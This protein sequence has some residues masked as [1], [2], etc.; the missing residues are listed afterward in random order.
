VE[1]DRPDELEPRR[2]QGTR[3]ARARSTRFVVIAAAIV[4]ALVAIVAAAVGAFGSSKKV[5]PAAKPGA[6][7]AAVASRSAEVM[8]PPP[9]GSLY[10]GVYP[11]GTTGEEDDITAASTDEY[12]AAVGHKVA[13]VYFSNNWYKSAAFPASTCQ[14][15]AARGSVPYI[16]LMLRSNIEPGSQEPTFTLDRI[17]KGD[18]DPQ[19]KAWAAGAASFGQPVM[20]EYGPEVN[21]D[22][23]PWNGS[24]NG[25]GTTTGFGDPKKA[26]GPE[27]FAAAYRHIID[28]MRGQGAH[29]VS[30]VF[31]VD[32]YGSPEE[33]WNA[34]AA[35]YPGDDYIDWLALSA[36]GAQDS[37]DDVGQSFRELVDAGYPQLAK[38]S[39]TKPIIIAEMG[40]D[41]RN[42]VLDPAAW[43]KTALTDMLAGKRWP[44]IAGFS[45]WDERWANDEDPANDSDMRVQDSPAVTKV[46]RDVLGAN[47]SKLIERP[48]T[49]KR[50]IGK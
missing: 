47:A 6:S 41:V 10:H 28:V 14:W 21:G 23:F 9:A 30:W 26:D 18:F 43:S 38:V 27:R 4:V 25:A 12:E 34:M 2:V 29:N 1:D 39:S 22:W 49:A 50:G 42:T 11:G 44:R 48:V 37:A 19:L 17:I 3:G 45:W 8:A 13:W 40:T 36:Y 31:H 15:I 20:A 32:V 16:R 7:A 33:P 46:F 24:F 5:V 35:Y